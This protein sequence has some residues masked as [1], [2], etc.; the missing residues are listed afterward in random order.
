[1]S[2]T[3]MQ[4]E[5]LNAP[6][7]MTR[8]LHTMLRVV[9]LE[10]S[11]EFYVRNLGMSV[12][13]KQDYPNG[14]FT[15]AFLGYGSEADNTVVELT[16]NWGSHTYEKGSAFGHIAL[17]V[18]DIYRVCQRLQQ[19]GVS[20]IRQPGPMRDDASEVIAFIE[21]PDGYSIELIERP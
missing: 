20:I 1:M 5:D 2:E 8:I 13:R 14:K 21:D 15:L 9:N 17:A 10:R 16:Y 12:L 6:A 3:A 4:K 11:I 18:N 7:S 19:Q